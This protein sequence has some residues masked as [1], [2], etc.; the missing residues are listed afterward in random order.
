MITGRASY[1]ALIRIYV[2]WLHGLVSI[3]VIYYLSA[4]VKDIV[5]C[6][7]TAFNPFTAK[8]FI[9]KMTTKQQDMNKLQSPQL[10]ELNCEK[11]VN[12]SL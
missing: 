11:Y 6:V 2:I 10:H 9:F 1:H 8:D 5:N 4:G 12:C 7:V 3:V